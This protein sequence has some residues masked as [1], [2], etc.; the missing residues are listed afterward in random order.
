MQGRV[1]NWCLISILKWLF[2]GTKSFG[3]MEEDLE[4]KAI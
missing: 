2:I 4:D 1:L 3:M